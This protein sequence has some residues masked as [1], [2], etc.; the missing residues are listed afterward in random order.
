MMCRPVVMEFGWKHL[1]KD[2]VVGKRVLEVG[3]YD[4]NGSLRGQVLA[5]DPAD[6][7]GVD[8]REGPGVDEV[9]NAGELLD[10]YG[11]ESFDVVIS[12]EMLEHVEDWPLALHNLKGVL[13]TG[14]VLLLTTCTPGFP[15]HD[16]P[17]DFWRFTGEDMERIFGDLV[18][19]DLIVD[20]QQCGVFLF[21]RKPRDFAE[22]DL[23][24]EQVQAVE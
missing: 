18:V 7:L 3:S 11:P 1:T 5:L 21:G 16:Y 10:R 19:E 12:T 6:Y 22:K 9:C 13:R 15:K 2:E 24:G 8:M 20:R 23:A 17:G 14:G 4:V